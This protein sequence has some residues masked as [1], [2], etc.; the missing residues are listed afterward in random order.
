MACCHQHHQSRSS[1]AGHRRS[2]PNCPPHRVSGHEIPV[3]STLIFLAIDPPPPT[4]TPTHTHFLTLMSG[5]QMYPLSQ[6]HK[7]TNMFV[8]FNSLITE[9]CAP[10]T[11]FLHYVVS[12]PHRITVLQS[13]QVE[14]GYISHRFHYSTLTIGPSCSKFLAL[15]PNPSHVAI[16]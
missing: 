9:S 4:H 13:H 3:S 15:P 1:T 6:H 8:M 16:I 11:H 10:V 2:C 14:C 7:L 12:D 5:I